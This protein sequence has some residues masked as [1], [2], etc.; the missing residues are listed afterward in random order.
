[1]KYD[2]CTVLKSPVEIPTQPLGHPTPKRPLTLG[3]LDGLC[4]GKTGQTGFF[5]AGTLHPACLPAL[6]KLTKHTLSL[7]LHQRK[8]EP[9][10]EREERKKGKSTQRHRA[11]FIPPFVHLASLTFFL[12][13]PQTFGFD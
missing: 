11:T 1:M 10:K 12:R 2:V 6:T 7:S 8:Q 13:N 3:G 9:K 4:T 5:R